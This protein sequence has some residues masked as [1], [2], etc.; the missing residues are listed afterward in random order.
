M[1]SVDDKNL[2]YTSEEDELNGSVDSVAIPNALGA[3]APNDLSRYVCSPD[4]MDVICGRGKSGPHPGNQR[5]RKFV[6]DKKAAYQAAKRREDKT[7]ITLLI[8]EE[9]RR[10]LP[11]SRFLL[12][13]PKT[14]MWYDAGVEYAREKVSHALRSRPSDDSKKRANKPKKKG[15]RKS[16]HAPELDETVERLIKE[17]QHLLRSMIDKKVFPVWMQDVKEKLST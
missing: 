12:K 5:F 16:Q 3:P 2:S 14:Q 17:Q 1:E 4:P 8:V 7:R 15:T 10:G 11:P 9:L 6:S 13:D